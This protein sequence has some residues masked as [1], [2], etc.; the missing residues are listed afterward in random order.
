MLPKFT[1][2]F[3]I[4]EVYV[5]YDDDGDKKFEPKGNDGDPNTDDDEIKCSEGPGPIDP[6]ENPR[7]PCPFVKVSD[8]HNECSTQGGIWQENGNHYSC[9]GIGWDY[10]GVGTDLNN[11]G[12]INELDEWHC[13]TVTTEG[14]PGGTVVD[15]PWEGMDVE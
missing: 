11:D 4:S 5:H 9:S 14:L 7:V 2:P 6:D 1:L 13:E 3:L 8:L 12:F 15:C 10:A